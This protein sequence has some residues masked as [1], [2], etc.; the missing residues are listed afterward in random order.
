MD[1]IHHIAIEVDNIQDSFDSYHKY[2]K[3]EISYQDEAMGFIK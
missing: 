2:T 1:K 3:C